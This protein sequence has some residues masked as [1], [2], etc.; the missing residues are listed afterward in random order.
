M[1][2]KFFTLFVLMSI[3]ITGIYAQSK[4]YTSYNESTKT[5]TYYYDGYFGESNRPN[6]VE[7]KPTQTTYRWSDYAQKVEKVVI[8]P[9]MN[10]ANLTSMKGMFYGGRATNILCSVTSITG[11]EYLDTYY[12]KDMSYMFYCC[13]KLE[14]LDLSTFDTQYLENTE[15]MFSNCW[16]LKSVDLTGFKTARVT[17]MQHMFETCKALTSLN[18]SGFNTEKVQNMSSMFASCE[19]LK[20]V[21][22]SNFNT[23]NVTSMANMFYGCAALTSVDLSGFDVSVKKP[24]TT[25]M[26]Y[27]CS[28]L[29]TIYGNTNWGKS[30]SSA[31]SKDMFSG[32]SALVGGNGTTYSNYSISY[33]RPDVDG[34][35]G[36]FTTKKR[37]YTAY[38]SSSKTLTYYYDNKNGE[39][40]NVEFY[41]PTTT[42][43]APR[44]A[45][46]CKD[47][48]KVAID[49]SMSNLTLTSLRAM[50]YGGGS[51]SE[52]YETYTLS[53]VISFSGLDYLKTY[54]ATDM[55]YMFYFMSSLKSLNL[56]TFVT[57][58]ATDMSCMFDGCS[59]LTSLD[60]SGFNTLKVTDMTYM[61]GL[62]ENLTSLDL[63][64][65]ILPSLTNASRMFYGCEK[66]QTIYCNVILH[67]QAGVTHSDDMFYRCL[68]LKGQNNTTYKSSN[69]DKDYA[70][71]DKDGD[72]GYFTNKQAIFATI[73]TDGTTMTLYAGTITMYAD[74]SW[75]ADGMG[76]N[77]MT[78]T[79]KEKI[80]KVVI[81]SSLSSARPTT[82]RQWFH[83]M[84]NLTKIEGISYLNTSE[85][86]SMRAMFSG[87]N[88]LES[89]D[90][91]GF[92]TAKVTNMSSM[93]YCCSKL[94]TI[95]VSN[96]NTENVT[97]MYCMFYNCTK[98]NLLNVANFNTAK[99]TNMED[100]FGGC[101]TVQ[102]LNL[103]HFNTAKVT[104]MKY[105]FSRCKAL[106]ALQLQNLN[107]AKVTDMS[108][109]F[110]EC[111][112]LK[113]V[114]LLPDITKLTT[115]KYMF[116]NCSLL[117]TIYCDTDF[118][119]S[120]ATTDDMF[121]GCTSLK[122]K[123]NTA[124]NSSKIDKSYA[125]PDHGTNL[126]GYFSA[127]KEIYT[128][129]DGN[130]LYYRYNE[131]Y[132]SSNTNMELYDP[133]AQPDAIR[134]KD[135]Y[136][137]ITKIVIEESMKN[138]PLT[139]MRF[140]FSGGLG[141]GNY[142]YLSKLTE[143]ENLNY[144]NTSNVT[145]MYG[146]FYY[147][148]A[149]NS[150][151][152]SSFVT[153]KVTNMDYMFAG[154]AAL[155]SLDLST[156][157]VASL[158]HT[159]SMF[160]YCGK[161]TSI[162]CAKDW[163]G[164][165]TSTGMFS[166]CSNL[167][168]GA[169]TTYNS[170]HVDASYAHPDEGTTN[171]GY[172]TA[173]QG[174]DDPEQV[175]AAKEELNK[176]LLPLG[177]IY[178]AYEQTGNTQDIA[179]LEALINKID[180]VLN[181]SNVTLAELNAAIKE[182]ETYAKA[183]TAEILL[184]HQL[185]GKNDLESLLKEG[186]SD[187][188]KQI[189]TDAIAAVNAITWDNT[190]PFFDSLDALADAISAI[191]TKAEKDL[192]AA[193]YEDIDAA[194]EEMEK[195]MFCVTALIDVLDE[196]QDAAT[197]ATA[198]ALL[199]KAMEIDEKTNATLAEVNAMTEELKPFVLANKDKVVQG[200]HVF[201]EIEL[202]NMLKPDDSDACKQIIADA[203]KEIYKLEWD[204]EMSLE[205]NAEALLSAAEAI[206]L[207]AEEDLDAQRKKDAESGGGESGG[208]SGG[209]GDSG[210]G[211]S[212]GG[213]GDSGGGGG[214]G[215]HP[216]QGIDDVTDNSSTTVSKIIRNGQVFI[217]RDGV[218]YNILGG[219]V[220]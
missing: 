5:L 23:S 206:L 170:S 81:H 184:Y 95:D 34:Q 191:Y 11:L 92:N 53:N 70:C 77:N 188:C 149:L 104:N 39:R 181:K 71:P 88:N 76:A 27:D 189:I 109:M 69:V 136:N 28:S 79:A 216:E 3:G 22:V 36:Y 130:T 147:C 73:S 111:S 210:G 101:E 129:R 156:F 158:N 197:L 20:S 137:Q 80:T 4:V 10:N 85:C 17:D 46:Y 120:S 179:E 41:H 165:T 126:P 103:S 24:A 90:V 83:G 123:Y 146:T 212:G 219:R 128:Y 9:S 177:M 38:D 193:R 176:W 118:S 47:V 174:A 205:E 26:F 182:A 121:Y 163:S 14:S 52:P 144:L 159:V 8:D 119:Q 50:F 25:N 183:H 213:G 200:L 161:L 207:K 7:Y 190:L 112:N 15:Y 195:W 87:C 113:A 98:V 173:K 117:E 54:N 42:Q 62:C 204:D 153:N 93:F 143:I 145:D 133:I 132:S 56:S 12:V 51:Y 45:S 122:G 215:S 21:I 29:K 43:M 44:W 141:G 110:H 166:F 48:K 35:A 108:Y 102:N 18:L 134:W 78:T 67:D 172:F 209:G 131:N 185:E 66:L 140:M 64:K 91:S 138:A 167:V 16:A 114:Y 30:I 65:F 6:S 194:K 208:G 60:V 125:R 94:T 135:C 1:M 72:P 19:A 59:S 148:L 169:G 202:N 217:I 151:D 100:M 33:A 178:Q 175:A 75:N 124:Y 97:T 211:G 61:F 31:N 214:G 196:T 2:K 155:T 96:F 198:Q 139:S 115:A 13:E 49:A 40:D 142:Y 168:G 37:V 106:K 68:A 58:K 127:W 63:S 157:S 201:L 82:C 84:K 105:M 116:Y 218:M 203:I 32:C 160:V 89:L 186:D 86:T 164:V 171:P 220:E 199:E 99:V 192:E 187:A 150:L 180:K 74:P 55:S 107:T 154:C 162:I 152:L 57:S